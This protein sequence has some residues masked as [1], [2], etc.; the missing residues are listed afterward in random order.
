MQQSDEMIA[1]RGQVLLPDGRP[2]AGAKVFALNEFRTSA[3]IA[4]R[5]RRLWP[6]Q[7]E[8]S[9]FGSR[10]KRDDGRSLA[11]LLA[12]RAPGF[13][14]QWTDMGRAIAESTEPVVLKLVPEV[15]VHGRIVDLEGTTRPRRAGEGLAAVVDQNQAYA[16]LDL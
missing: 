16:C 11:C 14:I 8:N 6:V 1:V 7:G 15:P 9:R 5:W 4:I 2:A 13:G 12:A 10:L 3:K